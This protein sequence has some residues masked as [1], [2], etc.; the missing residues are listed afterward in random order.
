MKTLTCLTLLL[1]AMS[2]RVD[3]ATLCVGTSA[4]LQVALDFAASNGQDDLI[5]IEAGTYSAPPGGFVFDNTDGDNNAISITGGWAQGTEPACS[6]R[7]TYMASET[8]L[9]GHGSSRVMQIIPNTSTDVGIAFLTFQSGH[10]VSGPSP[11]SGA[12]LYIAQFQGYFGNIDVQNNV[13]MGNSAGETGGGLYAGTDG[14]ELRLRNNV[15]VANQAGC[16]LGAAEL[17]SYSSATVYLTNNTVAFNTVGNDCLGMNP[18]PAGGLSLGG[19]AP[20][21]M[22]NNIFWG[23]EHVDLVLQASTRLLFNNYQVLQG[24][25]ASGSGMNLQI[26]P[27]FRLSSPDDLHLGNDS[28]MINVGLIPLP[29][30]SWALGSFDVDGQLRILDGAVDLGAYEYTELI[31]ANGFDS[32]S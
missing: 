1:L 2:A 15:F 24:T 27:G 10:I 17:F 30:T 21:Y 26:D 3:A 29:P 32:G 4:E 8:R 14:G 19:T 13:F 5:R 16:T 6:H 31:F 20:G 28:P 11:R 25:P 9:D 12:G 23:N 7:V 22:A 18:I